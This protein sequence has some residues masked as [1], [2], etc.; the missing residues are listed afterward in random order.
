ML[1]Y[2]DMF[3]SWVMRRI[4]SKRYNSLI[5]AIE[6]NDDETINWQRQ[7]RKHVFINNQRLRLRLDEKKWDILSLK[8]SKQFRE[9]NDFFNDLS[10]IYILRFAS[11]ESDCRLSLWRSTNS[12][13]FDIENILEDESTSIVITFSVCIAIVNEKSQ[14]LDEDETKFQDFSNITK[15]SFND[16]SMSVDEIESVSAYHKDCKD[17]IETSVTIPG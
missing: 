12:V 11:R 15:Y 13:A 7:R 2:R 14:R 8:L 6:N 1:L 5:V 17:K 10:L 16:F 9:S 3:N 4:L